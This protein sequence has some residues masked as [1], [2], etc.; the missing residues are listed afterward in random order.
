MNA[1]GSTKTFIYRTAAI[2]MIAA[3]LFA[4]LPVTPAGAVS[5]N[6]ASVATGTWEATAWPNTLRSG[7][8]SVPLG[9]TTVTGTGTAFLTELSVGNIIKTTLDI[10]VGTVA[11]ITSDTELTLVNPAATARTDIGYH[12]QGVGPAD[13]VTIAAGH[14]VTIAAKPVNQTGTVTVASGGI[15]AVSN[16]LTVFST[17]IV[18]GTLTGTNDIAF[19]VLTVNNGGV[20]NAGGN[21][22]Y[23]VSSLTINS[24]GTANISREFTVSGTT[25]ITGT[26]NFSSTSTTAR[27]MVFVGPVT[28]N[29]GAT[30]TEPA[31][32]NNGDNNTCD[33]QNNFT[34]NASTF[35]TS[36]AAS[37]A[38]HTFSG[39]GMTISGTTSTTIARVAVTGT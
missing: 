8:I 1:K 35:T 17:L 27:A 6:I 23:T 28:L 18:D 9:S 3:M 34:N 5:L 39:T 38:T 31:S 15:L 24:G 30:W 19:G 10:Q 4:A 26:V 7:T 32:G 14:T 13:N 22:A 11:S 21:G 37:T 16:P 36:D 12:V 2:F 33:F 25:S 20:V 29:S